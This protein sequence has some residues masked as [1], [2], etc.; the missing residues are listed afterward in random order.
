MPAR[1]RTKWPR[2]KQ[3]QTA[4][5]LFRATADLLDDR[6]LPLKQKRR[7]LKLIFRRWSQAANEGLER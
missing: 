2:L 6:R 3:I 7:I 5:I 1:S 4:H